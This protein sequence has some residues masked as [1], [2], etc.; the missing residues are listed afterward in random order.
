MADLLNFVNGPLILRLLK[1]TENSSPDYE[2][3]LT[4]YEQ[5]FVVISYFNTLLKN[6]NVTLDICYDTEECKN[7]NIEV[8]VQKD[9]SDN[10]PFTKKIMNESGDYELTCNNNFYT[11]IVRESTLIKDLIIGLLYE[12]FDFK[13]INH[14]DWNYYPV[15]VDPS[16]DTYN[17]DSVV[18]GILYIDYMFSMLNQLYSKLSQDDCDTTV[19]LRTDITYQPILLDIFDDFTQ[20][21]DSGFDFKSSSE[22]LFNQNLTIQDVN[23]VDNIY[24]FK[25]IYAFVIVIANAFDADSPCTSDCMNLINNIYDG[26]YYDGSYFDESNFEMVLNFDY[27]PTFDSNTNP[28]PNPNTNSNSESDPANTSLGFMNTNS[29]MLY[30]GMFIF[31]AIIILF[32]FFTGKRN[33]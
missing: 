25:D 1:D 22:I 20:I 26:S 2:I 18:N 32:L 6:T 3:S 27:N 19:N 15:D 13:F 8:I 24:D 28:N 9:N 14:D 21:Y 5:I 31:F 30:S 7:A 17:I 12:V 16:I 29:T 10:F 33:R 23:Y 4:D 11:V